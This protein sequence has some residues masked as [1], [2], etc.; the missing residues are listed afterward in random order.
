[1]AASW[2]KIRTDLLTDPRVVGMAK[3][4][5][6]DRYR[7]IG[8]LHAVWSLADE[9]AV[10]RKCPGDNGTNVPGTEGHLARYSPRD[11]DE[12]TGQGGLAAAMM[13]V[14]WLRAYPD[15][16]GL[17]DW[18]K[19]HASSAKTRDL[20]TKRKRKWRAARDKRPRDNGTNVPGTTGRDRGPEKRREEKIEKTATPSLVPP[21]PTSL[22]TV[23]FRIAW[24]DWLRDRRTRR[25]PV[26]E[27]AAQRQLAN[28]EKWGVAKAIQAIENAIA[29][30]WTGLFE[31]TDTGRPTP[32]PYQPSNS[33]KAILEQDRLRKEGIKP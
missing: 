9:H 25:K 28:L 2:I 7:I 17:P 12:L 21:L 27:L 13:A 29:N 10:P 4:L 14:D 22:D 11:I 3:D 15:G 26:T 24:E 19:H 18:D 30:G 31:P 20:E 16:L 6:T 32:A 23:E 8:L 33:G 5:D 1:M